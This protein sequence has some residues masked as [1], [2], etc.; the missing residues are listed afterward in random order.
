[1]N[2]EFKVLTNVGETN[3]RTPVIQNRFRKLTLQSPQQSNIQPK[4]PEHTAVPLSKLATE[5]IVNPPDATIRSQSQVITNK[6]MLSTSSNALTETNFI[7]VETEPFTNPLRVESTETAEKSP[8]AKSDNGELTSQMKK[9]GVSR[10]SAE[11]F[12]QYSSS[13]RISLPPNRILSNKENIENLSQRMSNIRMSDLADTQPNTQSPHKQRSNSTLADTQPN[14]ASHPKQQLERSADDERIIASIVLSSDDE[15]NDDDSDNLQKSLLTEESDD[16]SVIEIVSSDDSIDA[17]DDRVP[18]KRSAINVEVDELTESVALKLN[19]FFDNIPKLDQSRQNFYKNLDKNVESTATPR[20]KTETS[21]INIPETEPSGGENC[22]VLELEASQLNDSGKM[23]GNKATSQISSANENDGNEKI[24]TPK[25]LADKPDENIS[26]QSSVLDLNESRKTSAVENESENRSI[27]DESGSSHL[28]QSTDEKQLSVRE[29]KKK[30]EFEKIKTD[31]KKVITFNS[32]T[33]NVSATININIQVSGFSSNSS[34]TD[35]TSENPSEKSSKN[36]ET[37]LSEECIDSSMESHCLRNAKKCFGSK[38]KNFIA[39][40]PNVKATDDDPPDQDDQTSPDS[41]VIE[42]SIILSQKDV[43][44]VKGNYD[45]DASGRFESDHSMEKDSTNV[46]ISSVDVVTKQSTN[47]SSSSADLVTKESIVD[48]TTDASSSSTDLATK[49]SIVDGTTKDENTLSVTATDTSVEI[50]E[51]GE[52]LLNGIYD[53]TWRTPQLIKKCVSTK[54]KYQTDLIKRGKSRGFSLFRRDIIHS[55]L[56]STRITPTATVTELSCKD[57]MDESNSESELTLPNKDEKVKESDANQSSRIIRT[58][59]KVVP[60]RILDYSD[61]DGSSQSDQALDNSFEPEPSEESD[62]SVEKLEKPEP[63]RRKR[64]KIVFL[65]LTCN[66]VIEDE[67]HENP[68]ATSEELEKVVENYLQ[69]LETETIVQTPVPPKQN[70]PSITAKRKLF[71]PNYDDQTPFEEMKTPEPVKR[72][73]GKKTIQLKT[74]IPSFLIPPQFRDKARTIAK[75]ITPTGAPPPNDSKKPQTPYTPAPKRTCGF[76]ESLDS[77]LI[78][79]QH[80]DLEALQFRKNFKRHR[81]ELVTRL[82]L[83]YNKYVFNNQ[84]KDVPV[85]WNK[86]MTKTAGVCRSRKI[87]GVRISRVELS[88]KVVTSA[89]R[90]RDTL[91]HE[92][93]HA[94]AW[95]IDRDLGKHGKIFKY[96]GNQANKRFPELPAITQC[97]NYDIVGKFTYKCTICGLKSTAHSKSRKVEN[98]RCAKC[99]GPIEIFLNKTDKDGQVILVPPKEPSVFAKYVKEKYKLHKVSGATHADVMKILSNNFGKLT[100]EEKSKFK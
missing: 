34:D 7:N 60:N 22:D 66:E 44:L 81:T 36:D 57:H 51:I 37:V 70:G 61:D 45:K 97:H 47:G 52:Q 73:D 88:E 75:P 33:I 85:S 1:M 19:N 99:H 23:S 24:E 83:I 93:C 68:D 11:L 53:D 96:W 35:A 86:K 54:K 32:P 49:E 26:R 29:P 5:T 40:S 31:A 64:K 48:G 71:T 58:R 21:E 78:P 27:E 94:A 72:G 25:N 100:V 10:V 74:P 59:R 92:L 39:Y 89:D 9:L 84:L 3:S 79:D 95:I 43:R 12:S 55:E 46:S 98:I 62:S 69:S 42:S 6:L 30:I 80:C 41:S 8:K 90:L 87:A 56:D 14:T 82:M 91:I 18:Q 77:N 13:S 76:L 28:D 38:S 15:N 17:S 2:P 67:D 50:D 63:A 65:D 4:M 20:E 16:V